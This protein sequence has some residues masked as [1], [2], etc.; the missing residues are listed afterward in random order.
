MS[1]PTNRMHSTKFKENILI[2]VLLFNS[3]KYNMHILCF[4][5]PVFRYVSLT[6]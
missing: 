4:I 1:Q 5:L 3:G 2:N 6:L